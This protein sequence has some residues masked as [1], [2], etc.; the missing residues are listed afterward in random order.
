MILTGSEIA[1]EHA[2]GAI[3][4]RPFY[5]SQL[6]PNSYD[7][8][9]GPVFKTY[10]SYVL[11][12]RKPNTAVETVIPEAGLIFQPGRIYLGHTVEIMG[13][14]LYVPIIR[15]KS[16]IARLGLFIHVTA[17]IID[18][19]SH[20]QWTL[21]LNPVQPIR[22][23]PNMLIGQVTFWKVSGDIELYNGKYQGSMGPVESQVHLDSSASDPD[24]GGFE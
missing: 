22:L 16:S 21:Q 15:G 3:D 14:D 11:D 19:G 23:Y 8:R 13:S 10:A 20:N 12:A 2:K 4:I 17:D 24:T 6:N 18:I 9:L 7:F 1:R 5:P